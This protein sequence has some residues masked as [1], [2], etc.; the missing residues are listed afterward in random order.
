AL[1]AFAQQPKGASGLIGHA[2]QWLEAEDR[3]LRLGAA[4]L[5]VEVLGDRR[6]LAAVAD[7]PE[8]LD[9]LSRILAEVEQAPRSAERSATRR[10]LIASLPRTLSAVVTT[11]AAGDRGARWLEAECRRAR[12]PNLRGV[13]SDAVIGLRGGSATVVEALRRA[14]GE[15][16]KPLRDPSRLRKGTGRG[17]ASRPLR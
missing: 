17:K 2:Q 13:L 8:L 9:Y 4:A 15:S 11:A 10:R 12:H 16:A 14:L 1:T 5:V 6:V 3:D 7:S